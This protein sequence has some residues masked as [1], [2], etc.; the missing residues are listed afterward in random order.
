M[1]IS[2]GATKLPLRHISIR[3]PWHD[4]GWDGT[5]CRH[6]I[7]NASCL[8]LK[9][10]HE[11]R[12]DREEERLAGTRWDELNEGQRPPCVA[13]RAGFMAPFAYTRTAVQA[14]AASG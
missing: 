11:K 2:L 8:I 7:G 6:P 14:Y 9:S 5:V 3:V 10:I 13:E 4:A 1:N 12:D